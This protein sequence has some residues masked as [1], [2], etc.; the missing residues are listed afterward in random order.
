VI[1]MALSAAEP[2][3]RL[4]GAHIPV[5]TITARN[6]DSAEDLSMPARETAKSRLSEIEPSSVAHHPQ[7]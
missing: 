5:A 6:R 4:L 1:L 3:E 2:R 7:E